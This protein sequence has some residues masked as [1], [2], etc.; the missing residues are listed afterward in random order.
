MHTTI[1]P[2]GGNATRENAWPN[3]VVRHF[4]AR[5]N[6]ARCPLELDK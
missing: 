4:D 3:K 2:C 1:C 5:G 6:T